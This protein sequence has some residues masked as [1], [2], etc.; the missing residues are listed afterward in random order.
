L[1][2]EEPLIGWRVFP[3]P[4]TSLDGLNLPDVSKPAGPAGVAPTAAASKSTTAAKNATAAKSTAANKLA[5]AATKSAAAVKTGAAAKVGA[6]PESASHAHVQPRPTESAVSFAAVQT[7]KAEL[8]RVR[9]VPSHKTVGL[10]P[11]QNLV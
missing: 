5:A 3:L 1:C 4:L 8:A 2:P 6:A 11:V 10:D 7:P 9:G